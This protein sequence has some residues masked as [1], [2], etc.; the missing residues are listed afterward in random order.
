MDD[1]IAASAYC[2]DHFSEAAASFEKALVKG[3]FVRASL[4]ANKEDIATSLK[5]WEA[6][7]PI[8]SKEAAANDL[9]R[10][11][12]ETEVG[13]LVFELYENEAPETV[14]NFI[15]LVES[16]YYDNTTFH[17][18]VRT[19]HVFTGCKTGDGKSNPGYKIHGE[20]DKPNRRFPFLGSLTMS[21]PG[22]SGGSIYS[23]A[24][25]SSPYNFG[26]YTTFGRVVEGIDVLPKIAKYNLREPMVGM[27]QTKVIKATVLRKRDHEY[28]PHKVE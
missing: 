28:K 4:V 10:V 17:S 9:P 11:K 24:F 18:L 23:I 19:A 25:R 7:Q 14:A 3:K 13:D 2:T 16:G 12:L 5:A 20:S 27:E 22:D 1:L 26:Y 8:R 21:A 6:E 15:S